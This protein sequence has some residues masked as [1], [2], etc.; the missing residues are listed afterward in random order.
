[1]G[2]D[3]HAS[4]LQYPSCLSDA[5]SLRPLFAEVP[6]FDFMRAAA[7]LMNAFTIK[8]WCPGA[9]RPMLSGDGLV[10]RVRPYRGRL[11][12][13]QAAD[14][15]DLAERH[16]SGLIDLTSRANL[17][18]RGVSDS[19]YRPLIDGL[20][21]A[22]LLDPDPETEGR[23]N[24]I[25]TPFWC[26]DDDTSSLAAE[27]ECALADSLLALP[28]KFGFAIDDGKERVLA[29]ASADVRIERDP[30]GRLI[31]RA[32]GSEFG[33]LVARSDAV[34]TAVALAEWFVASGGA[35][36]G[37]GRMAAHIRAGAQLPAALRGDIEPAATRVASLPGLCPQGAV[38]GAVFGQLTHQT[39]RDLASCALAFRI[40]PWRMM[41][42]EGLH[43]MPRSL[44][45]VTRLDDPALRIVACSGAPRC[46]EAHA[47]TRELAAAL[48]PH[49]AP[50]ARL[51]VSGCA[52]GC[53]HSGSASIT[54]VATRDGFDLIRDGS[55]Q[56]VPVRRNLSGASI[57]ENPSVL[58]GIG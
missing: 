6:K 16:G 34:K 18:I 9:L 42:A 25:V 47:K 36:D 13:K 12:A 14:I 38:V 33:R 50:G 4:R 28:G 49:I 58:V 32:D 15:A 2:D 17:Q 52:K 10:V 19:E 3:C 35:R 41:L 29:V 23:R 54:L 53:A 1:M 11:D 57:I 5:C 24:L 20:A 46:P 31:V 40:T 55:T 22:G 7:G 30:E 21:R 8:G 51:H 48:A 39:L 56:D 45:V 37:R 26:A 27:L 44:D 43:E